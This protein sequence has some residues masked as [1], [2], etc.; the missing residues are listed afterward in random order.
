M[1]FDV[2]V[3]KRRIKSYALPQRDKV[4]RLPH[5]P[6]SEIKWVNE[7]LLSYFLVGILFTR[8]VSLS[9]G[10]ARNTMSLK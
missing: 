9:L 4:D 7:L 6:L 3:F 2:R 8:I 1:Y 5:R 10:E